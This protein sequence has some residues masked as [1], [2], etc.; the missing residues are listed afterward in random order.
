[1]ADHIKMTPATPKF[2]EPSKTRSHRRSPR[3]E[4]AGQDREGAIGRQIGYKYQS[5]R[6]DLGG[7]AVTKPTNSKAAASA[8]RPT[9]HQLRAK[10][11]LIGPEIRVAA[12]RRLRSAVAEFDKAGLPRTHVR[13]GL[14]R[15]SL[16]ASVVAACA[17]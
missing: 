11:A 14:F 9:T 10:P 2:T 6:R 12:V 4:R 3:G 8:R 7:G 16:P 17:E 15:H 13:C 1:M 5:Q